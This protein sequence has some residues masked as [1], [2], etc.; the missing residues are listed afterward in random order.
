[1]VLI[2]QWACLTVVLSLHSVSAEEG[3]TKSELTPPPSCIDPDHGCGLW[4]PEDEGVAATSSLQPV[5]LLQTEIKMKLR[6]IDTGSTSLLKRMKSTALMSIDSECFKY[7]KPSSQWGSGALE[8]F[9]GGVQDLSQNNQSR[10]LHNVFFLGG[11][12]KNRTVLELGAYDGL[13]GNSNAFEA[14]GWRS[15]L[16]D[17]NPAF[18]TSLRQN[19]PKAEVYAPMA[20][21]STTGAVNFSICNLPYL[22]GIGITD[23][24]V[25]AWPAH[26]E[27]VVEV[28]SMP[29]SYVLD[30]IPEL[31]ILFLDVEGAERMVL[32]TINFNRTHVRVFNIEGGCPDSKAGEFLESKGF[33]YRGNIQQDF[34]WTAPDF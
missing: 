31:D 32:E 29:L 34:V 1:M 3:T 6:P 33:V 21:S 20:I 24:D 26:I 10:I 16:M 8:G 12:A 30:N 27:K 25:A 18:M 23:Q 2:V 28:P 22:S 11:P 5:S 9:G 7:L 19:R 13:A 17:A 14:L 15:I 4:E